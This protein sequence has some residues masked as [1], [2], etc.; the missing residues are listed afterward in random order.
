M[1]ARLNILSILI[2]TFCICCSS[3]KDKSSDNLDKNNESLIKTDSVSLNGSLSPSNQQSNTSETLSI[4]ILGIGKVKLEFQE[5]IFNNKAYQLDFYQDYTDSIAKQTLTLK[6]SDDNDGAVQAINDTFLEI[7]D[8]F[9][10]EPHYIII[11]NCLRQVGDYYEIVTNEQTME[12][13]W[14]KKSN[15]ISY[16]SWG[17][18]LKSTVCVSQIDIVSNPVRKKQDGLEI[19]V[20]DTEPC[21]EVIDVKDN[22]LF[23]K[24]PSFYLDDSDSIQINFRGWIKWYEEDE[25]IINYYLAV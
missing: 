19:Q 3:N 24:Y 20:D 12:T 5:H 9:I 1:I 25:I 22:W 14:I 8:Y 11:F 23:I 13:M 10:E 17:N 18:F 21:W 6:W 15:L 4:G 7:K 2:I 16:K